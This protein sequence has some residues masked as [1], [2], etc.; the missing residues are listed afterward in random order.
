MKRGFFKNKN[1]G[2]LLVQDNWNI[3]VKMIKKQGF[4]LLWS[5]FFGA[6]F[7]FAP[8]VTAASEPIDIGVTKTASIDVAGEVDTYTFSAN[9]GDG[10]N[11]RIARTSGN[12]Y[13]RITLFGPSGREI[14]R[15]NGPATAEILVT[16]TESGTY[17][18]L[19]DNGISSPYTGDYSIF[20]QTVNS[21][22]NAKPVVF[23]N[24]ATGSLDT[25][26]SVDTYS[27]TGSKGD[28]AVIRIART[29]G[30]LYPRIT[31]YGPSGKEIKRE[32]GP[33]TAELSYT[34]VIPGIHTIL[35]DNGISSPYTGDY[36]LFTD[37]TSG[38]P[39]ATFANPVPP[40]MTTGTGPTVKPTT[41]TPGNAQ[42]DSP[43]GSFPVIYLVYVLL[44][45]ILI[46]A[47]AIAYGR[48]AKKSQPAGAAGLAPAMNTRPAGNVPPLT[49]RGTHH[50]VFISYANR[51][52]PIA[53][54]IC[55]YLEYRQI[56]CWIAPRDILPG[57]QYQEAIIDAI[58]SSSVMV[59]VFSV[60]SND[61]AHVL[62]ELN[63]AMSNKVIIIPFR[64]EDVQPSKSMK[65]L[66]S[67]PHWLD[68]MNPPMSQHIEKLE[69]TIRILLEQRKEQQKGQ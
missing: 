39:G 66:I 52:K 59:L 35:V 12:L 32:N 18:I 23:S 56:R 19:A 45:I 31:L 17:K 49:V 43:G 5:I 2:F 48:I 54:A 36:S 62:T 27:F 42:P 37:I 16:L 10:I 21:P 4:L 50:D 11:V 53:D 51:D 64:V 24:T 33:S 6:F 8:I 47:V 40:A 60:D 61:S 29:S 26:G 65:Y 44:A 28:Q 7:F 22:K 34:L 13:P 41:G 20:V 1:A 14:K 46:G 15:E 30:N 69:Q 63:E 3:W 9:T 25:P 55:N 58:D 68:A 57:R 67:V 38:N